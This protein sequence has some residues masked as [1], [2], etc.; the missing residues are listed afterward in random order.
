MSEQ[1]PGD[2][3]PTDSGMAGG[4]A[5]P[6]AEAQPGPGR[7]PAPG[8]PEGAPPAFGPPPPA[9][10]AAAAYPEPQRPMF[11]P[12][13]PPGWHPGWAPP[14]A[15]PPYPPYGFAPAPR[16][17]RRVSLLGAALVALMA[18]VLGAV[19]AAAV[20]QTGS[21]PGSRGTA[22]IKVSDI[23]PAGANSSV[24]TVARE[25]GPATVTIVARQAGTSADLGSGFV[26]AR[27]G[28]TSYLLTNNHVVEGAR[29]LNV[30]MPGGRNLTAQIVG[31]DKL[32]DLGVVAVNDGTLPLATFAAS[33]DL[34]VG[35][36]V[37]AIGS[38]LGN[39]GSVTSG[40]ISALHRTITAGDSGG[41]NPET[42]QD[43]L[44]TDA[45]INRG[46]SGGPLADMDGNVVG[47]NVAIAGGGSN[48]GFSIPSDLA[49]RVAELLIKHQTVGHPYLGIGYHTAVDAIELGKPFDGPGV[50]VSEVRQDGPAARAGVRVNDVIQSVDGVELDNGQ[51]LGGLIQR[52]NVG[53]S[54]QVGLRRD[55]KTMSV[56]ITLVDRP[57]GL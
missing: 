6:H 37:V 28:N 46:N 55:G 2:T 56:S 51:T 31:T 48:I 13:P 57:A 12:A 8:V 53:D 22:E 3:A 4:A 7:Q 23:A 19:G 15:G 39:E 44:Q 32:D 27:D 14:P 41:S 21:A 54:V 29:S 40:V 9:W 45:S 33:K 17:R 26:I 52:H 38:P 16:P 25:L 42:L 1:P 36:P 24:A 30:V 11:T 34:K 10:P 47:V 43:V 49:R 50:Q 5:E 20:V 18:L 35:E